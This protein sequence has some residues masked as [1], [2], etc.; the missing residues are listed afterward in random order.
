[1]ELKTLSIQTTAIKFSKDISIEMISLFVKDFL[2][3][4]NQ[5][6]TEP[7]IIGV[8]ELFLVNYGHYKPEWIREGFNRIKSGKYG[9]IFGQVNGMVVMDFFLHF[10]Q[11]F[12]EEIS[13]YRR[14][15]SHNAKQSTSHV[16][17]ISNP[18]TY[19]DQ[20]KNAWASVKQDLQR[21]GKQHEQKINEPIKIK[22]PNPVIQDWMKEF[23]DLFKKSG[24]LSG[25]K[26]VSIDGKNMTQLDFLEYKR[27]MFE[28]LSDE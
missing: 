4:L 18:I 14:K 21:I 22:A 8:A 11:E 19:D 6:M 12:T 16:E 25:V 27:K 3:F 5:N 13:E 15:E 17:F 2:Q 9:K 1:M 28:Q 7:Q 26:F 24:N 20:K 23:D 10:D